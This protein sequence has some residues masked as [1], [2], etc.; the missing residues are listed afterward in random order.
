MTVKLLNEQHLEFLGLKGGCTCLSESTLVKMPHCW[1]SHVAAHYD[2]YQAR[3]CLILKFGNR[4]NLLHICKSSSLP[5]LWISAVYI[6]HT[7]RENRFC[8]MR[9]T[10]ANIIQSA[11][12]HLC[13]MGS[14]EHPQ[15]MSWLRNNILKNQEAWPRGYK[16]W[17]QSQTQ[18]KAQR[19][20]AFGHLSASSQ[21][22]RLFWIWEWTQVL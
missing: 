4:N 18:N 12:L 2:H 8:C 1:K 11:Q 9:I 16:T 6:G 15:H 14:F 7:A 20:P 13:V 19:L 22:L 3:E 21:S 17:V 5:L 10:K